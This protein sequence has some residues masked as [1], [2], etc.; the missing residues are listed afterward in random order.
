MAIPLTKNYGHW[1]RFKAV[2]SRLNRTLIHGN[3]S[4]KFTQS[5][6]ANQENNMTM[7]KGLFDN[8]NLKSEDKSGGKIEHNLARFYK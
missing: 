8:M 2:I 7:P 6:R 1:S 3:A 4:A 5:K